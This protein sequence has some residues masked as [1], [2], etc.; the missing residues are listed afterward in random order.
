MRDDLLDAQ[1]CIDWAVGKLPA[2][3]DEIDDWVSENIDV[4]VRE[5]PPPATHNLVVAFPKVPLPSGFNVEV[6]AFINV[7]R[8]S[9]DLLATALF[10]RNRNSISKMAEAHFPI[11]R[12][13]QCF[14]DPLSG[15]ESIKWLSAAEKAILKD[16]KP[17]DGGNPLLWSLHQAD[18]MRKHRRML[19][20]KIQPATFRGIGPGVGTIATGW[21]HAGDETIIAT[22]LKGFPDPKV[23]ITSF[24][25]IDETFVAGEPVLIALGQF[26]LMAQTIIAR[27]DA[28]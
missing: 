23:E 4:E 27:F 17:Y 5:T 10:V 21:V 11:Y 28:P 9:L 12:S 13:S 3:Q 16:L 25:A 24:V 15:L 26:A 22:T 7:I 1:A 8:S 19:Y 18:I 2:F 14:V 6:G 20:V